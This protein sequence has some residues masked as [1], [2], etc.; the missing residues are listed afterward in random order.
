MERVELIKTIQTLEGN[1][2]CCGTATNYC[3][4][5]NCLWKTDCYLKQ[6]GDNNA[7]TTNNNIDSTP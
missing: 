1:W 7:K 5:H 6:S 2:P 4:Q 3:D